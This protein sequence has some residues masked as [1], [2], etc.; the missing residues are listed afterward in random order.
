MFKTTDHSL[1]N[2]MI[3][4][5]TVGLLTPFWLYGEI[6]AYFYRKGTPERKSSFRQKSIF[7]RRK[8]FFIWLVSSISLLI[9]WVLLVAFKSCSNIDVTLMDPHG[10]PKKDGECK[11]TK[12]SICFHEL[13]N[14]M[15]WFLYDDVGT[16]NHER[17]DDMDSTL[18]RKRMEETLPGSTIAAWPLW[19]S[20]RSRG[21][22][23]PE[24][25][26]ALFYFQ[27]LQYKYVR[28]VTQEEVESGPEEVYIDFN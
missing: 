3:F 12:T 11:Y 10:F 8:I 4:L 24:Y 17:F 13:L 20:Y 26:Y 7:Q 18:V 28:G 22:Q 5:A 15:D 25:L 23:Y 21:Y 16:C 27:D 14:N 9:V 19:D 1:A 6:S 2:F